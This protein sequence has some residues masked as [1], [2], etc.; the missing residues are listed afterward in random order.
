VASGKSTV[1]AL[2]AAL[3]VPVIDTDQ[4]AREVV[5]PGSALLER[6]LARFGEDLRRPDGSLDRRALRGII[7]ADPVARADLEALLHP[8][9]RARVA[10]VSVRAGGDYQ[11]VVVPLLVETGTAGQYDRVLVVDCATTL[12]RLRLMARD[13][14][15]AAQADALLAAQAS[16]EQRLTA[17]DDIIVRGIDLEA[18]RRD[19]RRVDGLRRL[20][21][22]D[23]GRLD[24]C[25]GREQRTTAEGQCHGRRNGG[26]HRDPAHAADYC[27]DSQP[28][29]E[30][31]G[32]ARTSFTAAAAGSAVR[33]DPPAHAGNTGRAGCPRHR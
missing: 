22:G 20:H 7:L 33:P 11:L 14:V 15:D 24:R 4:I 31:P 28:L 18:V 8:A 6:V 27:T 32:A 30:R 1:A 25:S 5:A 26:E 21:R 3:G 19:G 10:E 12:Q 2:F 16:R 23:L 17:A 29:R 9:I 13:Q